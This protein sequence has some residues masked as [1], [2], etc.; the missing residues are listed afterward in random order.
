MSFR[1]KGNLDLRGEELRAMRTELED[2][3]AQILTTTAQLV[4]VSR[5]CLGH[6]FLFHF[7]GGGDAGAKM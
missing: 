4:S 7:M 3:R 5:L 2:C 1:L 6:R